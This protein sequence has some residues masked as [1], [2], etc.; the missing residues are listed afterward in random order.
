MPKYEEERLE[1]LAQSEESKSQ[2]IE[3]SL[4]CI[5][6]L[7]LDG[8]VLSMN[9]GGMK[10][11]EIRDFEPL[12]NSPWVE[13]WHGQD[14]EAAQ[15]AVAAARNGDVGR[16]T[17]H[18]PT[19]TGTPKWWDVVLTPIL[20][21][22]GKP[23]RLLAVGRDVT[24]QR[25]AEETLRAITEGTAAV[26]GSD[27][28]RS[29]VRHLAQA[30]RV[31]YAFVAECTDKAK[32]R[33]RTLA[34][35]AGEDFVENI[36]FTLRGT[37]CEKVI[38]GEVCCYPEHLIFLF[39]EDQELVTLKAESYKGV[40]LY[41]SAGDILGHLVVMDDKPMSDV[42]PNVPILRIFA[43]RAGVELERKR[44]EEALRKSEER[45]RTLLDI[46]NAIVTKLTRDDLFSAISESLGR[47]VPFDRLALRLYEP[48]ADLLRIVTY[49]GPYQR[50]D[51]SPIGRA[52]DLRDSPAGWAF[53]HQKPLLRSN[54]E[55]DRQSSSEERAFGHGFRSLCALPL[56]IRGKSIGAVTLGSLQ[57]FQYTE[58]EAEF[59]MDVANQIAIAIDNMR[60][61]D[62]LRRL[63]G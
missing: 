60:A 26:T 55:T 63:S 54:L 50:A 59:L 46:N 44:A 25:Q 20:D 31:R 51:Y 29:L 47:V 28:F 58:A 19:L 33:V 1:A 24:E 5:E 48:A 4:D 61:Y 42:H 17:G 39:P 40:P 6:V 10:M 15:A 57:R 2:L 13:F 62:D 37:S 30:L 11:L 27:F 56:T 34:F 52:L 43:A 38:G 49:A 8:R 7:D 14:K 53:I 35:W 16:F 21:A 18:C 32:S 23:E 12:K 41:S 45:R 9:F 36:D 3:W 22:K